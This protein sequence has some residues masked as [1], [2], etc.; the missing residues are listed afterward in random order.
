MVLF[1]SLAEGVFF[2]YPLKVRFFSDFFSPRFIVAFFFFEEIGPASSSPGVFLSAPD[3]RSK[4]LQ[5]CCRTPH[6]NSVFLLDIIL[7]TP[8]V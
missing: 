6:S 8:R 5:A 7:L 4:A 3:E 2:F 1:P